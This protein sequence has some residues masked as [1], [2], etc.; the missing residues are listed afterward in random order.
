[1]A[2]KILHTADWHIGQTFHEYD[3]SYE[4]QKFLNWLVDTIFIKEIDVLLMS[5]DVFDVSNPAASSVTLFY[6][7]LKEAI[8]TRPG[9]QII[10][11]A[12]N[13]DSGARL[14][15]P[16]LLLDIYNIHIIGKIERKADGK[17]DYEKLIIPLK[18]GAGQIKAWC[19]AIP[20]LRPGD[21]P[22][23]PDV[24]SPYAE[25]IM[26]VY[27]EA[28][29]FA[30]TLKQPGQAILAM[31]HLHTL[32]A[33]ISENDKSERLILG[34]VEFVPVLTFHPDIVYTALGHIHKAQ[35]IA[36]QENIRYAGSPLPMSFSELNY[37]HQVVILEVEGKEVI[38]ISFL[39]IPVRVELLRIPSRP[40]TLD[41]VLFEL[42]QLP[43]SLD[44]KEHAPYLE[45]RVLLDGPEPSL[46]YKIETA[47]QNKY[48]RLAK[49]DVQYKSTDFL[50]TEAFFASDQLPELETVQVFRKIYQSRFN[51][52]VPAELIALFNE[53]SLEVSTNEQ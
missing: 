46:R 22:I 13:H 48:V 18:D 45:V 33:E 24:C 50:D 34:G 23:I 42:Q 4:H 30:C 19:M 38:D 49:I 31:G 16:K 36:G 3:R 9:L 37:R 1:M 39:D 14:E 17:I 25:G 8:T 47:I 21:Y 27:N 11:I 28:Y 43:T 53:V 20:F 6:K 15:A 35:K 44:N 10:I 12:G 7:F 26:E 5:G 40:K 32:N 2:L 29:S 51:N 52:E 41:R